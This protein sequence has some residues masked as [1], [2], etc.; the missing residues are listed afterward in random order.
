MSGVRR[1]SGLN[2]RKLARVPT[3]RLARSVL[4]V[5]SQRLCRNDDL[6]AIASVKFLHQYCHVIL[7]SLLTDLERKG[8]FLIGMATQKQ[9]ND[10]IFADAESDSF[11]CDPA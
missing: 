11:S 5:F 7:D 8:D 1:A 3:F 10:L 2:S 4:F 6:K 9:S